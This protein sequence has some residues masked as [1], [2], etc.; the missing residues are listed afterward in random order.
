MTYPAEPIKGVILAGLDAPGRGSRGFCH[1]HGILET[2]EDQVGTYILE[3]GLT[4]F[5][6]D[7]TPDIA[8][9]RLF[10]EIE[11]KHKV[12][13]YLMKNKKWDFFTI[14]YRSLDAAQ[15]CFWK[16][17][18]PHHPD[19]DPY[20]RDKYGS[21][22]SK[23]YQKLDGILGEI[24]EYLRPDDVLFIMS[25]HGFGPKHP[26][27]NQLNAWLANQGYLRYHDQN[28]SMKTK[29]ASVTFLK[30]LYMKLAGKL[31]RRYKEVFARLLPGIR[32]RVHTHLCFTGIDW[33]RTRAYSDTLFANIRINLKG[34]EGKGIVNSG[35]EYEDLVEEIRQA[36]LGCCDK[37]TGEKLVEQVFR[38][39]EIYYGPAAEKAPDLTIRWREDG[40]IS[41]IK[42]EKTFDYGKIP[43][44]RPFI[45][46]EDAQIISG[47][48]RRFGIFF[49]CG[50]GIKKGKH[51]KD[52]HI[53]DLAP[54]ILHLLNLP[55]PADMDGRV[56]ESML[57]DRVLHYQPLQAGHGRNNSSLRQRE[58]V[59]SE[60]EEKAI[61][62]RLSDLGYL[63]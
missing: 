33:T 22:I 48:H 19:H 42:I 27:N 52:I 43:A 46:A 10:D 17:M 47:D 32:N 23:V 37:R 25:D 15:H 11:Q 16:F 40:V 51:L 61:A 5:I 8:V 21:I 53:M 34:R 9:E 45:P 38:R 44:T 1:P 24:R 2:I 6:L 39:D 30:K 7:D 31:P 57:V 49:A 3:P 50:P 59:Y 28:V 36:L 29:Q 56:I 12:M 58:I 14:V 35:A 4:G 55:V 13:S 60:E 26:A 63:D 41:G 54:T 62:D 20:Q 18:D